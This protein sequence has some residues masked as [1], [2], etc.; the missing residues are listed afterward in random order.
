MKASQKCR[1]AITRP[2]QSILREEMEEKVAKGKTMC[3]IIEEHHCVATLLD[4]L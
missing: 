2:F 1:I 4:K 3:Q